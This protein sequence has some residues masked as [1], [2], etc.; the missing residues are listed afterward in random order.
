MDKVTQSISSRMRTQIH[1]TLVPP[2][3][4]VYEIEGAT[5]S[6]EKLLKNTHLRDTT[7]SE[8]VGWGLEMGTIKLAAPVILKHIA[9]R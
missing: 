4:P 7:Y 2:Y 5:E 9:G 6:P 8:P 3:I 1:G